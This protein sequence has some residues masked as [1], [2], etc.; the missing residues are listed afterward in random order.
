MVE[1]L[2]LSLEERLLTSQAGANRV[3]RAHFGLFAGSGEHEDLGVDCGSVRGFVEVLDEF[4]GAASAHVGLKRDP[5]GGVVVLGFKIEVVLSSNFVPPI[6]VLSLIAGLALVSAIGDPFV[7]E[8]ATSV[9]LRAAVAAI[10]LLRV[11]D[12]SVLVRDV[13][14]AGLVRQMVSQATVSIPAAVL[15]V[16][17]GQ[18]V[19]G[20]ANVIVVVSLECVL[21]HSGVPD[22][23]IKLLLELLG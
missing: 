18:S 10:V 20:V 19:G 2:S 21:S 4:S 23:L 3:D 6:H 5:L 1:V 14:A 16:D 7:G 9:R 12:V 11:V 13:L 22:N 15:S 17:S 8:D